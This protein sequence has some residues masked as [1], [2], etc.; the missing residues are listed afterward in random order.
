MCIDNLPQK[1]IEKLDIIREKTPNSNILKKILEKAQE[2]LLTLPSFWEDEL[3]IYI[4]TPSG[5][6]CICENGS[7]ECL[8]IGF[9]KEEKYSIDQTNFA[10]EKLLKQLK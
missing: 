10:I 5:C 6:W 7:I 4:Q 3:D 2:N 1:V 8:N 9:Y